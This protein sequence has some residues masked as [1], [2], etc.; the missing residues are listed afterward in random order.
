MD[1]SKQQLKEIFDVDED[2]VDH[3][4]NLVKNY[5]PD[6]Y[7]YSS[8]NSMYIFKEKLSQNKI[9]EFL[10]KAGGFK[11]MTIDEWSQITGNTIHKIQFDSQSFRVV[12]DVFMFS[13][14]MLDSLKTSFSGLNWKRS[15]SYA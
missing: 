10:I 3:V 11:K 2:L 8:G 1:F 14:L 9:E 6:R 15:S 5:N 4:Y 7:T 12:S 13:N